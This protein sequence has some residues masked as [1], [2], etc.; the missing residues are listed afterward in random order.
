MTSMAKKSDRESFNPRESIFFSSRNWFEKKLN[1]KE[2]HFWLFYL[3]I[4]KTFFGQNIAKVYHWSDDG[5]YKKGLQKIN[6]YTAP[7]R[8]LH[9]LTSLSWNTI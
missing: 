4:L 9:T 7:Q 5:A 1:Q 3:N 6:S 8:P 2:E